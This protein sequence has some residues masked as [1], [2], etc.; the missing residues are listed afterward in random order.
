MEEEE[1]ESER[2]GDLRDFCI[3]SQERQVEAAAMQGSHWGECVGRSRESVC[4]CLC[5]NV[6]KLWLSLTSLRFFG[7]FAHVET[8][9]GSRKLSIHQRLVRSQFR[10]VSMAET[11]NNGR[12]VTER[13]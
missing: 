8:Q 2:S 3:F 4:V 5:I 12:C 13:V 10:R 6:S 9:I 7:C 11:P 1:E